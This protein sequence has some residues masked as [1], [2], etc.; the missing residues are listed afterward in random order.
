MII[1]KNE[2]K[3]THLNVNMCLYALRLKT[4]ELIYFSHWT[5]SC[6]YAENNGMN[7]LRK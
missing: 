5:H 1:V 7:V 2:F 3:N 4:S 6:C